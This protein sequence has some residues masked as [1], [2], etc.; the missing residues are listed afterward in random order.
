[1]IMYTT[2]LPLGVHISIECQIGSFDVTFYRLFKLLLL[3]KLFYFKSDVMDLLVI[4]FFYDKC[5]FFF[6]N[7]FNIKW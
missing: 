2:A 3:L 6:F 5:F 7:E 4:V 1:M